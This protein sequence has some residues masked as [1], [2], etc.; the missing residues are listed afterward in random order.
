MDEEPTCK[1]RRKVNVE[2]GKSISS[3]DLNIPVISRP[4]NSKDRL[5]DDNNEQDNVD[6]EE[7]DVGIDQ[8]GDRNDHQNDA[9]NVRQD[10]NVKE[11]AVI[12]QLVIVEYE[13]QKFPSKIISLDSEGALVSTLTKCKLLVGNGLIS[14]TKLTTNGKIF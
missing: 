11:S 4:C 3:A 8:H 13:G 10:A 5:E 12:G 9:A 7:Q 2:L 6:S 14:E 1:K